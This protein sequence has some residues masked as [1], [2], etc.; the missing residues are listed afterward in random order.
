[1]VT[2]SKVTAFINALTDKFENKQINKKDNITGDFS[3]DTV[4]YP[5]VKAVKSWVATQLSGKADISNVPT[6]TSDLTNDSGFINSSAI[7]GKEDS[8][9]KVN[10]WSSIPND[11]RYPS[12]K[13]V[14]DSLDQKANTSSIPTKTSDLTNDSGFLTQHQD[15]SGK[16]D[17]TNKVVSWSPTTKDSNY[18][19]E[20]LV[21]SSLDLKADAS[22]IPTKT[23]DLT[24]DS[25]FLTQHQS[26]DGKTVTVEKQASA[27]SGFASTYIIK[28]G[29]SQAGVKINIPKDYLL[30]SA[31]KNV[32]GATPTS[33]E[34]SNG[35]VTGDVYLKFVVNTT[36]SSD[37]TS[38]IVN[39]SDL[40]D[41]VDYTAD[42]TTL[43]LSNN[44]FKVKNGG[45][46]T[47]QLATGVN[48]SLGY[49]ND[50]NSSVAK[51]ITQTDITNWNNAVS[52]GITIG[53]VDDEI[54]AYLDAI[55]SALTD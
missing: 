17:K 8:S 19:S 55:T 11:S 10:V 9:N 16:E 52:G 14:K 26:L 40:L 5:T 3:T 54:D 22:S 15:I 36:D 42:G 50:W 21:K 49:A 51:T 20:K 27:E 46:G 12:E 39:V 7:T 41:N 47:T 32:V 13:L 38:L 6:K 34:T 48:T 25:G 28:Q 53:D 2:T 1:M 4:S 44:Q 43:Q 18:P 31:T 35:L 33:E 29:G 30:Q 37:P 23:S 24:N 45:I